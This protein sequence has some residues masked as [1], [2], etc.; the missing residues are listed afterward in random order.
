MSSFKHIPTKF[1]WDGSSVTP[2]GM[3]K[4]MA[5]SPQKVSSPVPT[6]SK[7]NTVSLFTQPIT[8]ANLTDAPEAVQEAPVVPVGSQEAP[9]APLIDATS[10]DLTDDE[11]A[12]AEKLSAALDSILD[13]IPD[14]MEEHPLTYHGP[15]PTEPLFEPAVQTL[16]TS[17]SM[18]Y[19]DGRPISNA[20]H[21]M[22]M[23][24][25]G[26]RVAKVY[27]ADGWHAKL[28]RRDGKENPIAMTVVDVLLKSGRLK[29]VTGQRYLYE[30]VF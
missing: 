2:P 23:I 24:Y 17:N 4:P 14:K 11:K 13:M 19:P 3:P 5:P 30:G 15:E 21:L 18:V 6:A 29:E 16:D 12:A 9:V 8:E 20:N 28:K 10:P 22:M 25:N 27:K 7:P 26:A 1:K